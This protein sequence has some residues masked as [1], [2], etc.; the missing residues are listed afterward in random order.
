MLEGIFSH[1][2]VCRCALAISMCV[3]QSLTKLYNQPMTQMKQS[4]EHP[5]FYA[6]HVSF[7]AAVQHI[8]SGLHA[9]CLWY[10]TQICQPHQ[11]PRSIFVSPFFNSSAKR[12]IGRQGYWPSKPL[13]GSR[14]PQVA[15]LQPPLYIPP[16]IPVS[17][18]RFTMLTQFCFTITKDRTCH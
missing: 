6:I 11:H 5:L 16:L 3:H 2:Y 13:T 17:H 8:M 1:T 7:A 12:S 9:M 18:I 15:L 4:W 10:T 14:T